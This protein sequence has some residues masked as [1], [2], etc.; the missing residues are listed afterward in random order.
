[1]GTS[2]GQ[3]IQA[4]LA[5][6]RD[7]AEVSA[8]QMA[9]R[10]IVVY[11]FSLVIVRLGSKRFLSEASAFDVIVALMLGSIMS[12]AINGS[13][14]F[15]PTI[16]SGAVLV[17]LH[18]AFGMLSFRYSWFGSLVKGNPVLL[19]RD[20]KIQWPG[21]RQGSIS[22]NDLDQALRLQGEPPDPSQVHLA[23]LERN[24]EISVV[25]RKIEPRVVVVPVED[26]VRTVRIELE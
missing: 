16:L 8:G 24:G 17:G 11:G 25:S 19:I 5:L 21:L 4:L 15:F 7:V 23:Y 22:L 1:V 3:L 18:W 6:G 26:G 10:T 9:L 2:L 12:S 20:G 14:P 13:A